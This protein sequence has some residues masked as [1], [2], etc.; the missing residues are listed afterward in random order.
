[1]LLELEELAAVYIEICCATR[2][3]AF[4]TKTSKEISQVAPDRAMKD[5]EQKNCEE[6]LPSLYA[7]LTGSKEA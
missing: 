2:S 1:M 4:S 3:G 6:T 5:W 7:K